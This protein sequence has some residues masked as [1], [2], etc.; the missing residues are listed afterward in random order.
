M[1]ETCALQL[2]LL[3]RETPA[4]VVYC[5]A[6][7]ERIGARIPA[8]NYELK[9]CRRCLEGHAIL[10]TE[11]VGYQGG[12]EAAAR[13]RRYYHRHRDKILARVR[14]RLAPSGTEPRSVP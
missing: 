12:D 14:Q 3:F 6:H 10:P 2:P 8:A 9:L 4:V 5:E 11:N 7:L 13:R 1:S